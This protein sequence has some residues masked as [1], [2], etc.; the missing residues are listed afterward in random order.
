MRALLCPNCGSGEFKELTGK[1]R[2]VFCGAEFEMDGGDVEKSPDDDVIYCPDPDK[3]GSFI[4]IGK[5][6]PTPMVI[7]DFDG[8]TSVGVHFDYDSTGSREQNVGFKP[9]ILIVRRSEPGIPVR[10]WLAKCCQMYR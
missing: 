8:R 3:F 10:D 1:R 2:C 7:C 9:D 5:V 6:V 4:E